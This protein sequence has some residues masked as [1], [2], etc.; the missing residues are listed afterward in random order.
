MTN[1]STR[2]YLCAVLLSAVASPAA[3][4]PP[5]ILIAD[6]EG[7]DYGDWQAT[8]EAFGLGPARGTLP[9]Q[10]EVSGFEG[11]GLV[12]SYYGQD[13]TTGTL[14]SPEFAIERKYLNFLIG[15]GWHPEMACI[16]LL[17]EGN[18]VRTATGP[19][20]EPGGTERLDPYSWD[21][22]DLLGK[23]ARIEIVDRATGGWGHI[24]IDHIVQSDEAKG[25]LFV[26]DKLYEETYRP[27]F[28]F[29]AKKNWHND[30]NGLVYYAGEYH[31]FFQHN[32]SGINWGNMTWGH[33][34]SPDMVHWTQLD[35][36]IEP[37]ELGTIFSGSAVVDHANTAGWQTGQEKVLV[38]IYTSAGSLVT[39]P[40]PFTQSI[41]YSNDRG[42][43]WT[44]YEKNPVLGHIAGSNRDPK[45]VW[46]EPTKKWIM[47]LFLDGNDYALFAS[48]NL[49]EWTRLCNVVL[50]DTGECPDFFELPVDGDPN[51]T[52]W[53]F[54]GGNGNYLIGSFDEQEFKPESETLPSEWG[55][56]CY[57]AQ[58]WSDIPPS[59]GRRLQIAWMAG[60]QYPG[61]PFN[62]QMSFPRVLTL[63]TTP[64][65]IRLYRRPVAEIELLHGKKHSWASQALEPGENLLADVA[66]DLLHIRA[67]IEPAGATA[68][69]FDIRGHKIEYSAADKSI[70]LLGRNAP[71]EPEAGRIRLEILV[72]RTSLE[73]FGGDGR[74]SMS[75]CFLP[76]PTNLD[77]GIYATGDSTNVVSLEVFELCSAWRR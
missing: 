53:V 31:M 23:T 47:A 11:E 76:D 2:V 42:R 3:A 7:D 51:N 65:G 57:A 61:M 36:A 15:G 22:A 62:Q 41:A 37:D 34:V 43:T 67:E 39:P 21:V 19:N 71:L 59:D 48:P 66:G 32:P 4:Q 49:K 54:W 9:K 28:H 44:K 52:K 70:S 27:Q 12:N 13:N 46:H 25:T 20:R 17:V 30:P 56:N 58:T 16:N 73:V 64:E 33:A 8:G 35:H 6:F 1:T 55:A 69:G 72:D 50:P 40:K 29:S 26:V 10:M 5:D 45:V 38:A 24:N 75:S 63:R 14:T 68:F 77:V 18:V 74:V 60:G